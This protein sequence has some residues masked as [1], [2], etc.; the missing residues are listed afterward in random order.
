MTEVTI[1]STCDVGIVQLLRFEQG[2]ATKLWRKRVSDFMAMTRRKYS[3][4]Y[5][6][7]VATGHCVL[8]SDN[9]SEPIANCL[10]D[11]SIA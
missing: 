1:P 4:I 2:A 6:R 8:Q 11:S 5:F 10:A 3:W 7:L 9:A